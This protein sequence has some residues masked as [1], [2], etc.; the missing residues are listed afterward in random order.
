VEDHLIAPAASNRRRSREVTVLTERITA[1]G[2]LPAERLDIS[3]EAALIELIR[4]AVPYSQVFYIR[5]NL[6]HLTH[7]LMAKIQSRAPW[8]R[9]Q[10]DLGIEA[11]VNQADVGTGD[12]R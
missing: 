1:D 10:R 8:E 3:S 7:Y 5:S 2:A 4:D 12:T 6:A 9:R 11:Q